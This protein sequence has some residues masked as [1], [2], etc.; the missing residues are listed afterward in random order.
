[1]SRLRT[2]VD[3]NHVPKDGLYC[4]VI[5]VDPISKNTYLYDGDGIYTLL[6]QK[7]DTGEKGDK[8]DKGDT[9]EKGDAAEIFVGS[10]ITTDP[11]TYATVTNAGTTKTAVFNFTIPRGAKGEK[12]ETGERGL[13]G[14]QGPQGVQGV[15]GPQG[16]VG[17]PFQ[18]KKIYKSVSAMEADF[19]TDDVNQGEFVIIS[20]D[21][22]NDKDNSKLY[23]KGLTVWEYIND[24]SGAQGI[25]GPQGVQGEQGV[26][27]KAATVS[28]GTV[29]TGEAGSTASVVN[30]GTAGDAV[31]NFTIPRGEKGDVADITTAI[32][33]IYPLKVD[34]APQVG[35]GDG[36]TDPNTDTTSLAIGSGAKAGNFS[37]G[38]NSYST[39]FGN[40]SG[41]SGTS[42]IALGYGS[43]AKGYHSIAVGYESG[44]SGDSSIAL[45]AYSGASSTYS[46][47]VGYES[48]ASGVQSTA[49][50][51]YSSSGGRYSTAV[52]YDSGASGTSSIAL[53]DSTRASGDQSIAI[54]AG[55]KA[56][57]AN[58]FS[59]GDTDLTRRITHVTDPTNDQDA[60]TKKYVDNAIQSA[61]NN[62]KQ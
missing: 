5:V 43:G 55:S 42:S 10:T 30:V 53:G 54:G 35:I 47:A 44:A 1:M 37:H 46:T 11:G 24:L 61:I 9:G 15:Q 39:A 32:N 60:A 40:G 14:V 45:G 41:A 56:M 3:Q 62:L 26:Q 50:G 59:V 23:M 51:N 21:D 31:L 20:T 18:I 19:N 49:V 27:G 7:G 28:V 34:T 33:N 2:I 4:N 13:Q 22:T 17:A 57:E 48:G 36:Q 58:E 52:G 6:G 38:Q 25:Q 12:G 8:G 29:T 16:E